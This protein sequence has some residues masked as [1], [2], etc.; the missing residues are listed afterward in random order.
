MGQLRH[1][2]VAVP[3]LTDT[4]AHLDYPQFQADFPGVLA[5]AESAGVTRFV[6]IGT[7]LESSQR[8]RELAARHPDRKS[9]RLNS[10][11]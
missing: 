7:G 4:H 3:M 10:S 2:V 11:H 8:V 9:T 1:P 6:A 5:R